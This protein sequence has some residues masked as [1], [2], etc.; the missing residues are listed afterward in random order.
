MLLM[1]FLGIGSFQV[2]NKTLCNCSPALKTL[3]LLR[4]LF[5]GLLFWSCSL[6]F[7]L[8]KQMLRFPPSIYNR[9]RTAVHTKK[10]LVRSSINVLDCKSQPHSAARSPHRR[11]L[12]S[13]IQYLLSGLDLLF[14]TYIYLCT[15]LGSVLIALYTPMK[16]RLHSGGKYWKTIQNLIKGN[17][18]RLHD[19]QHSPQELGPTNIQVII[20]QSMF[21]YRPAA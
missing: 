17:L 14:P 16:N 12:R 10:I 19:D 4:L 18:L 20:N 15:P 7:P 3:L 8:S 6:T 5:Y 13:I 21:K 1:R 2:N 11:V 9:G